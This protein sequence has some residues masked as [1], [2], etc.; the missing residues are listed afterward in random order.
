MSLIRELHPL[1]IFSFLR[2]ERG[3]ITEGMELQLVN[4]YNHSRDFFSQHLCLEL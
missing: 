4:I 3:K 1:P 2:P